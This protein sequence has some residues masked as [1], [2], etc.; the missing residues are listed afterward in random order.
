MLRKLRALYPHS[1]RMLR[2]QASKSHYQEGR[3]SSRNIARARARPD[4]Q[5]ERRPHYPG[6]VVERGNSQSEWLLNLLW[7]WQW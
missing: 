4:C 6:D 2:N 3:Q 7:C 5:G 1:R